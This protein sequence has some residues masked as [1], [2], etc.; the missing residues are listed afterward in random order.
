MKTTPKKERNK[1]KTA[2]SKFA[3]MPN[4]CSSIMFG[5]KREPY[6]RDEMKYATNY[7]PQYKFEGIKTESP[8]GRITFMDNFKFEK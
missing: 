3:N 8:A 4:R 5:Y 6:Y 1:R 7:K 2:S